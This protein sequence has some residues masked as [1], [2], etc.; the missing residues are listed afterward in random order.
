MVEKGIDWL[1]KIGDGADPEEFTVV[2]KLRSNGVAGSQSDF[3]VTNKD[4]DGWEEHEQAFR[5]AQFSGSGV[6]AGSA[7][8][9]QVR[10]L[11]LNGGTA[12]FQMLG[13][14]EV[15]EGAFYVT[16]WSRDGEHNG[17]QTYSVTL[18]AKG[19]VTCDDL[20]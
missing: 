10:D 5:S 1:L 7:T 16:D 2:S 4:S 20:P 19:P 17:E 8:Q 12:S 6:Y 9:R 18:R 14:T 11:W 13:D 3:E 15:Y